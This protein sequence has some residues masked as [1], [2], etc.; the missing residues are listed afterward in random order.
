MRPMHLCTEWST[1]GRNRFACTI[2]GRR[3]DGVHLV[4]Q[5]PQ[6]RERTHILAAFPHQRVHALNQ[7]IVLQ[8]DGS[9]QSAPVTALPSK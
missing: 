3:A 8:G 4:A 2:A 7:R 6:A 5:L 9:S 1:A